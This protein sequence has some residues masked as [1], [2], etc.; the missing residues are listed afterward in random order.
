MKYGILSIFLL[1]SSCCH[2]ETACISDSLRK[3]WETLQKEQ[4]E[5]SPASFFATIDACLKADKD[6]EDLVSIIDSSLIGL[7]SKSPDTQKSTYLFN[8]AAI[9]YG[10]EKNIPLF[11][12][13]FARIHNNQYRWA[14]ELEPV[15][16]YT[17]IFW[18]KKATQNGEQNALMDLARLAKGSFLTR[19]DEAPESMYFPF[20]TLNVNQAVS[21]LNSIDPTKLNKKFYP[22]DERNQLQREL[23]GSNEQITTKFDKAAVN[24]EPNYQKP[25]WLKGYID[26]KTPITMVLYYQNDGYTGSYFY[27]KAFKKWKGKLAI[28]ASTIKERLQVEVFDDSGKQIERFD[29]T[30]HSKKDNHIYYSTGTWSANGKNL[31]V[32]LGD[33]LL[34]DDFVSCEEMLLAP[35]FVFNRELDFGVGAN[36]NMTSVAND[37][38]LIIDNISF[39]QKAFSLASEIRHPPNAGPYCY[40]SLIHVKNRVAV[41]KRAMAAY[42]PEMYME[43]YQSEQPK[44]AKNLDNWSKIEPFSRKLSFDFNQELIVLDAKLQD[45]LRLRSNENTGKPEVF[46]KASIAALRNYAVGSGTIEATKPNLISLYESKGING[47]NSTQPTPESIVDFQTS[48]NYALVN[49]YPDDLISVLIEKNQDLNFGNESPIFYSLHNK[50]LLTILLEKG[51]DINYANSFGKTP[52]FYSI[53]NNDIALTEFLLSKGANL[54]HKYKSKTDYEAAQDHST[55]YYCIYRKARTPLMHA[56]QHASLDMVKL[57]IRNGA[58][59]SAK[60]DNGDSAADYAKQANKT[61]IANYLNSL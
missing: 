34:F 2:A 14:S 43:K 31:R 7:A 49:D 12:F 55:D 25:I 50:K 21:L 9:K 27:D 41:Y 32:E 30:I 16:Y 18:L 26:E 46:S 48:L 37:C 54:N 35:D 11:Q 17:Y 20:F 4:F 3:S 47:I 59:S 42:A 22:Y 1:L 52:L 23:T 8:K 57:L 28:K 38:P 39:A 61:E 19:Y 56:A 60:D 5:R 33:I 24:P 29:L 53:Q 58:D 45:F 44:D 10:A 6:I 36:S 15:D 51:A 13:V 40:G